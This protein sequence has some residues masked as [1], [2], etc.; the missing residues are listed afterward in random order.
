M[1]SI[2]VILKK[3]NRCNFLVFFFFCLLKLQNPK[4]KLNDDDNNRP[5]T[6][7]DNSNNNNVI[8]PKKKYYKN[9]KKFLT[10]VLLS[11]IVFVFGEFLG[12]KKRNV[13]IK[14]EKTAYHLQ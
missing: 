8:R 14:V 3:M 6:D 5:T 13:T 9:F 4:K 1:F 7:V 10:M 2:N 11:T 12:E